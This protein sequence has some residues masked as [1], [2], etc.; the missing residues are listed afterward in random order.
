MK[1]RFQIDECKTTD[2]YIFYRVTEVFENRFRLYG[3]WTEDKKVCEAMID[4][5]KPFSDQLKECMEEFYSGDS[6]DRHSY[7]ED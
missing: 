1:S 2:H 3:D 6:S 7:E 5:L 4:K